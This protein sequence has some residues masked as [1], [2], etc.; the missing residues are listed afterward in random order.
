MTS[1]EP[2]FVEHDL[3]E[4]IKTIR[5]RCHIALILIERADFDL[6]STIL[7]DMHY[8][9]QIIIDLYCIKEE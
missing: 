2:Q 7:E 3:E 5:N 4:R 6:L 9:T 8:G 1:D